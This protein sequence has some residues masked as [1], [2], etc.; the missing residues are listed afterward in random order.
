M[1]L[2]LLNPWT[3]REA[4]SATWRALSSAAAPSYFLSPGWV[5]TWLDHLPPDAGVQLAVLRDGEGPAAA[6][7]LGHARVV[8][9][10]LF[11]STAYLLNQTGCR[12]VDQVYIE[13]N[14]FLCRPGV[15]LSIRDL[16]AALP[17]EWEE[18]YLSGVDPRG[19]AGRM[20]DRV[21]APYQALIA[22]R[23]PAPYVDLAAVAASGKDYLAALSSN[24]RSQIRRCY[25]QYEARGPLTRDVA[26][27]TASALEIYDDLVKM[28][29]HWW[30]LRGQKGAFANPWFHD[31]HRSLVERRFASG[32]IQL[33][34]V[35]CGAVTAGAVYNFVWNGRVF[36]YQSGFRP[37]EDNRLKPG[38]ICH[39][40]AI[41]H[42]LERGHAV[43]DF[44]ASFDEY[45]VRMSTHQRELVWARV[46]KPR[47]KFTVERAMRAGALRAVAEYRKVKAGRKRA[48]R[49][50]AA[51]SAC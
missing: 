12:D 30:G 50:A 14:D 33:V 47:L 16:L 3:E 36:F 26:A 9:Q 2:Q 31:F 5:D 11:H 21:E 20:L 43:Y 25:K 41:R 18:L 44:M 7:F 6:A 29:Q 13:D 42:S 40:E 46:Q 19:A 10:R 22:N 1:T 24:T 35:R 49:V 39:T 15:N 45:K 4:V 37:E 51:E 23:I 27:D 17:G 32:E 34:R 8:R 48:P 28:H 38:F